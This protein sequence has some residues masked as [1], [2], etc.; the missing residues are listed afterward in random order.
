MGCMAGGFSRGLGQPR[1]WEC[2]VVDFGDS[3][4]EG[5][6]VEDSAEE[7]A[8]IVLYGMCQDRRIMAVKGQQALMEGFGR[9]RRDGDLVV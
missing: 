2:E 3:R 8:V 1:K 9:Q 7:E 4:R 6:E 5:G